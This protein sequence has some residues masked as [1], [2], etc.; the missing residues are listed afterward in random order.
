MT[1]GVAWSR[2]LP[3]SH[4]DALDVAISR[5]FDEFFNDYHAIES[6][7][8]SF[9]DSFLGWALPPKYKA[10]YTPLFAKRFFACL[11]TV[12]WKL[13]QLVPQ[14]PLLSCTAGRTGAL[15]SDS[16]SQVDS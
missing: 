12:A 3:D 11:S 14:Q 7:E 8:L 4:R 15:C 10:R 9:D 1:V 5:V 16:A 13:T 2:I 6:E